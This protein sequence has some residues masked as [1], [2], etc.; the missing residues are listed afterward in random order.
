MCEQPL[1]RTEPAEPYPPARA[2]QV[3]APGQ[4]SHVVYV[5]ERL[6]REAAGHDAPT[7]HPEL[8]SPPLLLPLSMVGHILLEQ[9]KAIIFNTYKIRL[10]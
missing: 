4:T 3:C 2:V 8:I 6:Q 5:C 10:V 1:E 9:P 7:T